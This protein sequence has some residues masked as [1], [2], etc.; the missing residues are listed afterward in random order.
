ML[1]EVPIVMDMMLIYDDILMNAIGTGTVFE[2]DR[3][4]R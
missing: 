2:I 3:A 4:Q 1:L